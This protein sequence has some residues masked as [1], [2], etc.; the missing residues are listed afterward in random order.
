MS[1][2][3]I[4]CQ[5]RLAPIITTT[6][7]TLSYGSVLDDK[8]ATMSITPSTINVYNDVYKYRD[9][10]DRGDGFDHE[11]GVFGLFIFPIYFPAEIFVV[12]H[13]T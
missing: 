10:R 8:L 6:S 2:I 9:H 11:K 7:T 5:L 1:L 4:L 12:T 13:F 3:S